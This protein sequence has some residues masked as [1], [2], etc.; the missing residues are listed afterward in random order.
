MRIPSL[1]SSKRSIIV[2]SPKSKALPFFQ[3]I[4]KHTYFSRANRFHRY[5]PD[6]SNLQSADPGF[7]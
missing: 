3:N 1:S 4:A 2:K 7:A 5:D 6:H